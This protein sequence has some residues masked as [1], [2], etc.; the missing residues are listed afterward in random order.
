MPGM[1]QNN[2]NPSLV[3]RWRAGYAERCTSGSRESR[4]ETYCGDAVKCG[5]AYLITIPPR[6][7]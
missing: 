6:D 1:L 3:S 5:G 7:C 4:P 2:K